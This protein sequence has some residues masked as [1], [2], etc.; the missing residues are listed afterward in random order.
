LLAPAPRSATIA[1]SFTP[2]SFDPE[3]TAFRRVA[4]HATVVAP[5][6]SFAHTSSQLCPR[7]PHT[8]SELGEPVQ[9]SEP[10]GVAAPNGGHSAHAVMPATVS[11]APNVPSGHVAV[12]PVHAVASE[13]WAAPCGPY[14]RRAHA[15]HGATPLAPQD[16]GSQ[17]HAMIAVEPA[18]L[19]AL[20]PQEAHVPPTTLG[21]PQ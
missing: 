3:S 21:V 7:P 13:V 14:F 8:H 10:V 9:C 19:A 17:T 16:P 6:G 1:F 2:S 12:E 4:L 5:R 11:D 20:L 15:V 18:G